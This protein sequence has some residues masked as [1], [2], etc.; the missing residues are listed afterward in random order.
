MKLYI[1]TIIGL[2]CL[3]QRLEAQDVVKLNVN[4]KFTYTRDLGNKDKPY[5]ADMILSIGQHS[6]RYCSQRLYNDND[7]RII[8][9]RRKEQEKSET[10]SSGATTV[11]MGGPV[12]T[13]GNTG[14]LINE[15]V[16]KQFTNKKLFVDARVALR[17]YRMETELPV[18]NW[19]ITGEAKKIGAYQC[20][21]ATTSF[22]GRF[23]EAWFTIELPYSDGPWKL[24]GLPGLIIAARDSTNE[25]SFEMTA[26]N[27]SD[28][29]RETTQ[30]FLYSSYSI[31]VN[32]KDLAKAKA[33]FE[34]D[35][36]GVIAAQAPNARLM[37]RNIDEP[38][39]KEV[40]K[41][42]K[43]NPIER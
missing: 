6:S 9:A 32:A 26:L 10:N 4:Y 36:A 22:G 20:Q 14:A 21:K 24:H 38:A 37:I 12:L 34:T 16:S 1:T 5:V 18:I 39:N 7:P 3:M 43:Y 23:Y 8:E 17:S 19:A 29:P 41:I 2:L 15:E 35:P 11:V 30:S 13:I 28:D 27:K 40:V 42:K 31:N 25:V 33:A